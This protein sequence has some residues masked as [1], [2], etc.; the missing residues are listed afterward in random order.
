MAASFPNSVKTFTIK[1]DGVDDVMASD[2]NDLQL[3]TVA[4]QTALGVKYTGALFSGWLSADETWTYASA[5]TFT[6]SGDVTGKYGIGD[7]IKLTQTSVKYFYAVNVVYS[8]PNTTITITGGSD[9]TLA[10]AAITANYYSKIENPQGFPNVFNYTPV[11]TASP[12]NPVLGNGTLFGTLSIRGKS[13]SI[14]IY[15]KIGSTTTTGSGTWVFGVPVTTIDNLHIGPVLA[16]NSGTG[17]YT[18]VVRAYNNVGLIVPV[19]GGYSSNIPFVWTTDDELWMSI[20]F[21]F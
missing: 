10:N 16:L 4:L 14:N 15:L 8:A 6:V 9:H 5:T 21:I 17:Y 2:V 19:G 7:K 13:L 3:E 12:T 11:W 20:E 1:V 18:S